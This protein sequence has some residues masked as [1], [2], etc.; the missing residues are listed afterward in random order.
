MALCTQVIVTFFAIRDNPGLTLPEIAEVLAKK[1]PENFR[2]RDLYI[3]GDNF[4]M[5]KDRI[6]ELSCVEE[7]N[8][9]YFFKTDTKEYSEDD[10][11]NILIKYAL[12]KEKKSF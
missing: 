1:Y 6:E 5:L 7:K 10:T 4:R 8:N 12:E 2:V 11:L 9:K 3:E